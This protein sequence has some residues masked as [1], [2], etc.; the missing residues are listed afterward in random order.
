M[1][2]PSTQIIGGWHVIKDLSSP[3][4]TEVAI[5]AIEK[6]TTDSKLEKVLHG[7]NQVIDGFQYL[8]VLSATNGKESKKY[9]A[10]VLQEV[11]WFIISA[12]AHSTAFDGL[13]MAAIINSYNRYFGW[14]SRVVSYD[15]ASYDGLGLQHLSL[16]G[17]HSNHWDSHFPTQYTLY[18]P[19]SGN[20]TVLK[21]KK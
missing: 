18:L 7:Q 12:S 16:G 19:L 3:T 14:V 5:F 10:I 13:S 11:G 4:L 8:L 21:E 15:A 2:T 9:L 17:Q 20:A 1:A 6:G